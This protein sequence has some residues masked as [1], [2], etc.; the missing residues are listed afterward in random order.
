[1]SEIPL[2]PTCIICATVFSS[3]EEMM[4]HIETFHYQNITKL[5]LRCI[6]DFYTK[7]LRT[8]TEH[9]KEHHGSG[10][11]INFLNWFDASYISNNILAQIPNL[12]K[13]NCF[14]SYN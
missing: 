3:P 2:I 7:N 10:Y 5:N 14:H 13:D 1:M 8:F 6:C 11:Q 12:S 9:L 4:I